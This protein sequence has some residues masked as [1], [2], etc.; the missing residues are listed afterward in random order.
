MLKHV[1]VVY[2]GCK[3]KTDLNNCR[4]CGL[5]SAATSSS[6]VD[7]CAVCLERSCSVAAEGTEFNLLDCLFLSACLQEDI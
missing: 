7:V 3:C 2:S 4:D 6:E 5:Q 1:S